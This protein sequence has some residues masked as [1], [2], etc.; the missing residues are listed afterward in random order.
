MT[1]A[2]ATQR[3][4]VSNDSGAPTAGVRI[5]LYRRAAAGSIECPATIIGLLDVFDMSTADT[6]AI[7]GVASDRGSG[8]PLVAYTISRSVADTPG[9]ASA[10]G[11]VSDGHQR[12]GF[13]VSGSPGATSHNTIATLQLDDTATGRRAVLHHEAAMG[14]DTYSDAVDLSIAQGAGRAQLTGSVAWFNTFRSWDETVS[15]DDV[16]FAKVGGS[17][18]A[19]DQGPAITPL[20][21]QLFFTSDQRG[22]LLDFVNAPAMISGG[23]GA[24][25]SAGGRLVRIAY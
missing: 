24:V 19:D 2:C 25:L 22:V 23:L 20:G 3:Y 4:A 13:Q 5:I 11:F 10:I 7:R 9:V 15:V 8:E 18:V 1:F 17:L 12:F 6:T 16:P 14:V 21:D